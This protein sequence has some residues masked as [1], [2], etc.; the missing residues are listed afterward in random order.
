MGLGRRE[1]LQPHGRGRGNQTALGV[2]G[3]QAPPWP[4]PGQMPQAGPAAGR[5]EAPVEGVSLGVAPQ[6]G[7]LVASLQCSSRGR[8]WTT[9]GFH[10]VTPMP[11]R[12]DHPR[13]IP[14]SWPCLGQ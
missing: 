13:C 14:D 8:L 9:L 12:Q 7:E 2:E 6:F 4:S 11:R 3:P 5:E 1:G 10:S